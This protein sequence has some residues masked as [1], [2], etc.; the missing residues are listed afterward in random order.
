MRI[1]LT[2]VS[3]FIGSEI[4][5]ALASA[6]HA[7]TGLV[8]ATSRRDHINEYVDRFVTGDLAADDSWPDLLDGADVLVHNALDRAGAWASKEADLDRHFQTN[9]VNSIRLIRAAAPRPVVFVST[10]AVHQDMRPRWQGAPDEDHP[11]RPGS[12]YG[13]YKAAVEAH[14]WAEHAQT[15]R[16]FAAVRPCA[17]YGVDPD[18]P[19]SIGW[20]VLEAVRDEKRYTR[21]GG[22][23]FVHVRDVAAATA[24]LAIDPEQAGVA[25]RVVNLTDCYARWSD[26]ARL[27]AEVQGVDPASIGVDESTPPEPRNTFSKSAARSLAGLPDGAFTRGHAGLREHLRELA[28]LQQADG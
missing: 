17:V 28:T 22:G 26:W 27:A 21:T 7:V 23:K 8:R 14:L 10:I 3:G 1:A 20:P 6:G 13:A 25:A 2:G 9:L 12:Y 18:R 16:P 24:S 4:A 15:G 11:T 5:R 19:R